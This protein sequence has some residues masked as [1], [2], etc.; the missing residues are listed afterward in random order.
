M[1]N[2]H[3]G[4]INAMSS[5]SQA[6]QAAIAMEFLHVLQKTTAGL[7]LVPNCTSRKMEPITFFVELR[8]ELRTLFCNQM[9]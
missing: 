4:P 2:A 9:V 7:E 8:L 6:S 3:L 1:E 5:A